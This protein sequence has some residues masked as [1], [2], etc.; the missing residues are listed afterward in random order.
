MA[1]SAWAA[2]SGSFNTPT[3]TPPSVVINE[4]HIAEDDATIHS[5]FIELYNAGATTVNLSGW[6]FDNGINFTF[7]SGTTLALGAY[8]VV[9]EDPATMTS[10]YGVSGAGVV[11]W[12]D[13]TPS[14]WNSL[15]NNGELVTLRDSAG[16]KIDEVDYGLGFPWPTVGDLPSKS[17]ELINPALDNDLGGSW[18]G[19][20][21]PTPRAVNSRFAANAAPAIRQVAHEAVVPVVGQ[22]WMRSAQVVRISAKVTDPDAMGSVSLTYQVVEPGDYIKINDARFEAPASWTRCR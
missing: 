5:E 10:R 2:A 8:L 1:G 14:Q 16:N 15:S 13:T 19:S 12:Q 21:A 17:M 6:F 22:Q 18:R 7:P 20:S 4:L 9:C 3:Y 11:S